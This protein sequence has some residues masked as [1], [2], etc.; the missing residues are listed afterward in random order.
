[1]VAR[2]RPLPLTVPDHPL[3]ARVTASWKLWE[4]RDGL[5]YQRRYE[6]GEFVCTDRVGKIMCES[7]PAHGPLFDSI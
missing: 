3:V 6:L 4:G 5:W 1:M 7:I 2:I